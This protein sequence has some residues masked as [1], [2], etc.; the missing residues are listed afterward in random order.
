[1]DAKT[2]SAGKAAKDRAGADGVT[3]P[4]IDF[5]DLLTVRCSQCRKF[6]YHTGGHGEMSQRGYIC[7]G[8]LSLPPNCHVCGLLKATDCYCEWDK[9]AYG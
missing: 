2:D 6:A 5:K 8:C 1:M 4:V 3:Q 7:S 9:Y